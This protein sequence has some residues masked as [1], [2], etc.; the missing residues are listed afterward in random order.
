MKV[1]QGIAILFML[2]LHLF[3]RKEVNGIYETFP[4][5]NGIPLIYYIGLFGDACVPIY[6]FASGYGLFISISTE[7]VSTLKKN[8]T[9][10]LKLLLNAWIILIIFMV[11][12]FLMGK[13]EVFRGGS[14][15]FFLNIFLLSHSYNGAW[16]YLQTYS[17]LVFHFH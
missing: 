4:T 2:S 8:F 9:R 10:I 11:L 17:I 7:R 6:L 12:A 3:A 13:P 16:W 14:K 5:I 15:Q 1:L